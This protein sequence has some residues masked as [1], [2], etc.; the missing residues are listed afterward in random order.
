MFRLHD[1]CMGQL[2]ENMTNTDKE[3]RHGTTNRRTLEKI[4]KVNAHPGTQKI[5]TLM[6]LAVGCLGCGGF[7][8][9]HCS[10]GMT[11]E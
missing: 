6:L 4:P 10:D 9:F 7:C 3:E 1:A 8:C 5:L 2:T 11:N